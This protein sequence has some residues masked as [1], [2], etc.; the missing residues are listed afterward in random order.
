MADM[1]S[2]VDHVLA[3]RLR[4]ARRARGMSLRTLGLQLG[5]SGSLVHLWERGRLAVKDVYV[6]RLSDFLQVPLQL[7]VTEDSRHRHAMLEPP[8]SSA[9]VVVGTIG[10]GGVVQL[11]DQ[12]AVAGSD[13]LMGLRVQASNL[14]GSD[15]SRGDVVLVR[16]Q[17]LVDR[18]EDERFRGVVITTSGT[19]VYG[20]LY[21]NMDPFRIEENTIV[22]MSEAKCIT[23]PVG[24]V[25]VVLRK[26]GVLD[27]WTAGSLGDLTQ[28]GGSQDLARAR[29]PKP[30]R[31]RGRSLGRG[32]RGKAAGQK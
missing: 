13:L 32:A 17:R 27:A 5:V 12:Q 25:N 22:C 31:T 21:W 4:D 14:P 11:D 19:A 2:P 18:P 26:A 28:T 29:A 7:R 23:V 9:I 8:T 24:D 30:S 10:D 6:P 16:Q 1:K 20:D 15:I 3:K